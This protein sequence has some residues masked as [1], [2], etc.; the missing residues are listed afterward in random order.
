MGKNYYVKLIKEKE[1]AERK[2]RADREAA[3][4]KELELARAEKERAEA[5][6]K[7][8]EIEAAAPDREKLSRWAAALETKIETL[9]TNKAKSATRQAVA[10]LK[11]AAI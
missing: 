1:A 4:I 3:E 10:T 2:I 11:Q 6:R 9:T 7:A 8:R 5:E